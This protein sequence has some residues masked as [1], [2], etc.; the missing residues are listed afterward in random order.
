MFA[1]NKE[2]T[3]PHYHQQL[4]LISAVSDLLSNLTFIYS[5]YFPIFSRL[6]ASGP[7]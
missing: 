2:L 3:T 7:C 5:P 4:F 1:S 6:S